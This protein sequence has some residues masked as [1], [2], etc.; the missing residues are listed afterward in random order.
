[1]VTSSGV[2]KGGTDKGG[3]LVHAPRRRTGVCLSTE[4][5]SVFLVLYIFAYFLR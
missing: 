1:M 3:T 5:V 4:E 2:A